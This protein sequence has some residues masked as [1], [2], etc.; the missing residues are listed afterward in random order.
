MSAAALRKLRARISRAFTFKRIQVNRD[1]IHSKSYLNISRRNSCTVYVN[2][3]GFV[4][5]KLYLKV[6]VH[7]NILVIMELLTAACNQ[8]IFRQFHQL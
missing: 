4:E 8:I 3:L 6:F 5:V 2:E 7:V 1:I